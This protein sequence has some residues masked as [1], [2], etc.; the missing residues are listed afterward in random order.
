LETYNKNPFVVRNPSFSDY[1][2]QETRDDIKNMSEGITHIVK[3][4]TVSASANAVTAAKVG[5]NQGGGT[6]TVKRVKGATNSG[7]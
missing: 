6:H 7:R 5:N 2:P 4:S 1:I 3:T